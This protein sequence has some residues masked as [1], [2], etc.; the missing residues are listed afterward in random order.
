[1]KTLRLG[2]TFTFY[3]SAFESKENSVWVFFTS[4]PS[5]MSLESIQKK[6][7]GFF[8]SVTL[9]T[10]SHSTILSLQH[11]TKIFICQETA[12]WIFLKLA[13]FF[14]NSHFDLINSSCFCDWF[15]LIS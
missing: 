2:L 3:S 12:T 7:W 14:L 9:V 8:F 13:Y 6:T 10:A 11:V 4:G 1:M 15:N 5:D